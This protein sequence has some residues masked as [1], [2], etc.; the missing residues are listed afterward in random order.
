MG[1][2]SYP[3]VIY[4]KKATTTAKGETSQTLSNIKKPDNLHSLSFTK[5]FTPS[6]NQ[7]L[8]AGHLEEFDLLTTGEFSPSTDA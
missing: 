6:P 2:A 3:L 5:K 8:L 7:P 1:C 4:K